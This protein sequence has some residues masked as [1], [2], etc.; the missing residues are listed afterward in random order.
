MT[1]QKDKTSIFLTVV[2]LFLV[3][4]IAVYGFIYKDKIGEKIQKFTKKS[5][6]IEKQEI[7]TEKKKARTET[8]ES[9]DLVIRD[10]EKKPVRETDKFLNPEY[11]EKTT[12]IEKR[13]NLDFLEPDEKPK[14]KKE[15]GPGLSEPEPKYLDPTESPGYLPKKDEKESPTKSEFT[16]NLP[17]MED[18]ELAVASTLA[19]KAL[20]KGKKKTKKR[21]KHPKKSLEKRITR[22]EKKLGVKPKKGTLNKR[23]TRLEKIVA[24]KKK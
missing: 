8:I 11:A 6:V 15:N 19:P 1:N 7:R 22:L 3:V 13:N 9:E 10:P 21:K 2:I 4:A 18:K 24:K 12:E 20:N 5:P 23:V 17:E 14:R 16:K